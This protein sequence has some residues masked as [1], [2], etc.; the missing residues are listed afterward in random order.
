M[1]N[2]TC[3]EEVQSNKKP[4]YKLSINQKRSQ[5]HFIFIK[6]SWRQIHEN[7]AHNSRSYR[8]LVFRHNFVVL[9]PLANFQSSKFETAVKL[10][11]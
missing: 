5:H 9:F 3:V 10:L 6:N 4:S 7:Y 8:T 11:I 1:S 2:I